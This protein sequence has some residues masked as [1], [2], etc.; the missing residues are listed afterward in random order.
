[1]LTVLS[2]FFPGVIDTW[3]YLKCIGVFNIHV[4]MVIAIMGQMLYQFQGNQRD[5]FSNDTFRGRSLVSSA[6]YYEVAPQVELVVLPEGRHEIKVKWL[7][8]NKTDAKNMVIRNKSYLIAKGYTLQEGIDFE[9][10]FA[11]VARLEVVRMFVAY[12]AHKNFTIYQMDVKTTFLNGLLKEEVFARPTEKH[13][14]EVKRIFQYLQKSIN[15]GLWYSKDYGFEL[16]AYSDVELAGCLDDYKST[17]R[18]LQFLGDKIV[19]WS[20]KK[21]DCTAMS[22]AEADISCSPECKI[23][24]QILLDHP[25]SYALTATAD[26]SAVVG[27]QGFV[28]KTKI[29]I[30]QL[31]HDVINHIYVDYAALLWWDFMNYVFQKKDYI[32]YPLFT[33]LIIADL[34]KKFTSIS[35]RLEEDYHSI[36]D[37]IPLIRAIDDYKE[38]EM[39]FVNVV[40]PMNQPK[41]AVST[42]GMH[43]TTPKAHRTPTF[44]SASPQEKKRKQSVGEMSLPRKSLKVTIK[45][46][47]QITTP[48]PPPGDDIERDEMAEATHLSLT[49]HKTALAAEAKENIAKVQEKLDEE[50]IERMVEGDDDD[51]SNS[52]EFDD[53][54]FNNYD[55]DSDTWIEPESH[56]ENK[57]VVEDDD[58]VSVIEKKDDEKK[59]DNAEKAD[60]AK[61]KDDDDQTDHA[62]V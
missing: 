3:T 46:K 14:K 29:N 36:K 52:S 47:K 19:S 30:L 20:S 51:E 59:D 32:Q 27:Y 49:L 60:D 48:I 7:W 58:D 50:E 12:A 21:Q 8:K 35:L 18:G 56:K 22:T 4:F 55:D 23:V 31:F 1:M 25:L 13:L 57:K 42:Q 28:D 10:L 17:S 39:V 9:E 2:L 62:L 61:E 15:N 37:D 45:K 40:A 26:V 11:P 6:V 53:S 24:G 44:T 33:K 16:I 34:M 43:R 54:M 5:Y 41:P 38:Y